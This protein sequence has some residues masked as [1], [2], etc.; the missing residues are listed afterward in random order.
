MGPVWLLKMQFQF[1]FQFSLFANK[2][3]QCRPHMSRITYGSPEKQFF[4]IL[5]RVL[6]Y[7]QHYKKWNKVPL[8]LLIKWEVVS[9]NTR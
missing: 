5:F 8:H 4:I 2:G 1:Q 3:A 9:S 6:C 7:F